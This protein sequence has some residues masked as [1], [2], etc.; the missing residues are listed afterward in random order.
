MDNY[1]VVAINDKQ[2]PSSVPS[3]SW[4]KYGEVYTVVDAAKMARQRGTL[5]YKLAE[6]EFPEGCEYQYY[7]S[8][9]FRPYTEDDMEA[10]RAVEELLEEELSLI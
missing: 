4:I 10:E 5:G 9:R 8:S 6:V 2:K 1:R 3:S 7:T